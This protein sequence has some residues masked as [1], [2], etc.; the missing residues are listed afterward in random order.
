MNPFYLALGVGL[1]VV[2]TVDL[3][4]TTLWVDG[5]AGPVSARLS[6]GI[7]Q[8]M[9]RVSGRHTKVLSLAGPLILVSTLLTWV[10]LLWAGWTFC[11]AGG[12]ASLIDTSDGGTATWVG[13][14]YF[15]GYS[16]F[17]MGNGDYTPSSPIWEIAAS[18]TTASGMVF[19]TLGVSYVLNVLEAVV[20][21]R[22]FA[23]SV[24]GLGK[25]SESF[26]AT[27]WDGDRFDGF[28]VPMNALASDLDRLAEQHQAYPI[29]HYYY[30][31]RAA[32]SSALA[33]AVFDDATTLLECGVPE[34]HRPNQVLLTSARA[35]VQSYL[36][37]LH[38]AFITES[39][40]PPPSPSLDRLREAGVPTVSK[41]AFDETMRTRT[42]R[43]RK[44]LGMVAAAAREWPP[45][46]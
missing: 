31:D 33:V 38:T 16:M 25:R 40:D 18:L 27:G 6:T 12:E 13:R 5:G 41:D 39:D 9:R 2:A 3:F 17:T 22:S 28:E 32:T 21:K 45:V 29:L 15:V 23:S 19:V 4:W 26:V 34:K 10:G 35:S 24:T 1:L 44:L 46:K 7:W 20:D 30:S 42:D 36:H 11:F 37:T 14:T 43:R 8:F